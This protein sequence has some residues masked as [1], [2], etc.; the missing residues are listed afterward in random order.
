MYYKNKKQ[1]ESSI[2]AD[3]RFFY[4]TK[5]K[6]ANEVARLELLDSKSNKKLSKTKKQ[7]G[8]VVRAGTVVQNMPFIFFIRKTNKKAK[9]VSRNDYLFVRIIP[10]W[11]FSFFY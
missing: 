9:G 7:K 6:L 11:I 8:G 10:F 1:I 3:I 4:N 5:E 2:T